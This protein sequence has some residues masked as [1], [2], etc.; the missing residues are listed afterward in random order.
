MATWY[1]KASTNEPNQTD[2][3]SAAMFSPDYHLPT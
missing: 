2:F 1:L 3:T